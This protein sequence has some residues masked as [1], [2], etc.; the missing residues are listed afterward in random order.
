MSE[1]GFAGEARTSRAPS[2]LFG[3][4]TVA[5]LAFALYAWSG[6]LHSA[7]LAAYESIEPTL[8]ALDRNFIPEGRDTRPPCGITTEGWAERTWVPSSSPDFDDL[9]ATVE[10][11]G[12][13]ADAD[14]HTLRS[15]ADDHELLLVISEL[16][17]GTTVATVTSQANA[18]GCFLR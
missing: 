9:V 4:L 11:E 5:L 17:D 3:A 6:R 13:V 10:R 15:T 18:L 16:A 2:I 1:S 7:D 8:A 12:W 14:P